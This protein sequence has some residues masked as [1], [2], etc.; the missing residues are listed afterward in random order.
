MDDIPRQ[1]C[2]R[3][4][5]H[6]LKGLRTAAAVVL[7]LAAL[8]SA[9]WLYAANR[10][11]REVEAGLNRMREAGWII[12][13]SV[14]YRSGW[15]WTASV[16]LE[17]L[18]V[19]GTDAG[20][21]LAWSVNSVSIGV[22]AVHPATLRIVPQGGQRLKLGSGDWLPL[23]AKSLEL[24]ADAE[25]VTLSGLLLSIGAP[26]G[27]VTMTGMHLKLAGLALRADVNGLVC[28]PMPVPPADLSMDVLLTQ[29]VPDA[30]TPAAAAS[31]WRD[32]GGAAQIRRLTVVAGNLRASGSGSARL[33]ASL[34]PALEV[35]AEVYGF[36]PVL[37]QMVKAG[38]LPASA[39]TAAKAVLGLLA[40]RG[41]EAPAVVPVAFADGVLAAAGFPLLRLPP[42]DWAALPGR[43]ARPRPGR[44][45]D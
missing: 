43:D 6:A 29:A 22:E 12:T 8:H 18:T 7:A 25:G 26:D 4:R 31:A 14:P 10:T 36:R 13:T 23:T 38:V 28:L 42:M 32:Q 24:T 19:D 44:P 30:P 39:A 5:G 2:G 20:V 17:P 40:G 16:L 37:D 27:P 45:P 11:G 21:P 33:D 41:P 35:T 3:R 15:P 34:Q 1:C 9:A